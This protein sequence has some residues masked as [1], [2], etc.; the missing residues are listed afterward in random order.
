MPKVYSFAVQA[1]EDHYHRFSTFGG[2]L[3]LHY[4]EYASAQIEMCLSWQNFTIIYV[5]DMWSPYGISEWERLM[6]LFSGGGGGGDMF[7]IVEGKYLLQYMF[8]TAW[9]LMKTWMLGPSWFTCL[10]L[11]LKAPINAWHFTKNNPLRISVIA[12]SCPVSK[13]NI[14]AFVIA[15][16]I[17]QPKTTQHA[18]QHHLRPPKVTQ[19]QCIIW[20]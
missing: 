6:G 3:F 10:I 12:I 13:P 5:M 15:P 8:W 4:W 20:I 17:V 7:I 9:M 2:M 18:A 14:M 16:I 1:W 11:S 19:Q